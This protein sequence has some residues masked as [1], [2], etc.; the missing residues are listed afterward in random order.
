M[1]LTPN[2]ACFSHSTIQDTRKL[3]PTP[4]TQYTLSY[5]STYNSKY[6]EAYTIL[7]KISTTKIEHTVEKWT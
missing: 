7:T 2:N 5:I 1:P 6:I 4:N 3:K